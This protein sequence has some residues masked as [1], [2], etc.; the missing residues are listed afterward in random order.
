MEGCDEEDDAGNDPGG[1]GGRFRRRGGR[2]P[3]ARAHPSSQSPVLRNGV[4]LVG[5]LYTDRTV[6]KADPQVSIVMA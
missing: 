4:L 1:R 5:P 6:L 3:P 2:R